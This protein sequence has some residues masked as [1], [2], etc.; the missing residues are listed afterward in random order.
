MQWIVLPQATH[1]AES[2][3]KALREFIDAGGHVLSVGE[4]NLAYDPYHRPRKPAEPFTRAAKLAPEKDESATVRKLHDLLAQ[5]GLS[6]TDLRDAA[7][8]QPVWGVEFRTVPSGRKTLMPLI[9]LG[10]EPRRIKL[11]IHIVNEN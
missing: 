6:L 9:N 11:P 3:V 1:V 4:S 7:S 5:G 8:D 2:T 10:P